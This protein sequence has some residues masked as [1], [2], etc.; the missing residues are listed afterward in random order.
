MSRILELPEQK[1]LNALTAKGLLGP[2]DIGED[3]PLPALTSQLIQFRTNDLGKESRAL[4][5][6][7]SGQNNQSNASEAD[8][9]NFILVF[10]GMADPGDIVNA[11]LIAE[12]FQEA[13]IELDEWG[14]DIIGFINNGIAGP[15]YEK[16]G[17]PIYEISGRVIMNKICRVV[18]PPVEPDY[19]LGIWGPL[20]FYG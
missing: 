12:V 2:I 16:D 17:R 18:T 13:L 6:I 7:V 8:D 14:N 15:F 3:D 4:A 9:K 10:A 1:I 20:G 19:G 5:I 11:R